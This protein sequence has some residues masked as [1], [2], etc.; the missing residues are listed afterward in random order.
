[1][2]LTVGVTFLGVGLVGIVV[3]LLPTTP[4]LLLAI[5]GFSRSS[6][7]FE[8]WLRGHPRLGPPIVAW[9]QH[10]SIALRAKI[11]ATILMGVSFSFP[12]FLVQVPTIARW[13][14]VGLL[15]TLL[16]F[17]WSR[18]NPPDANEVSTGEA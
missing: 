18:P 1:M 4:F 17:I 3:P 10:R 16:L 11:L 6:P 8:A 12:I 7:R 14:S 13:T 15:A 9:E 5:A 2:F